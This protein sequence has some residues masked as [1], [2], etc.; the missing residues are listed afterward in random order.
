MKKK[1]PSKVLSLLFAFLSISAL[2]AQISQPGTPPSFSNDQLKSSVPVEKMPKVEVEKL[3]MEDRVMDTIKDIPWRFGENIDV[4]INPQNAGRWDYLNNGDKIW[5]VDVYSENAFTINLIFDRYL[6]PPGAELYVYNQDRSDVIGA[7][8]DYNN[9]DDGYFATTL[10]QG[11]LIT[12]EYY[13]PANASF[14]GELNLETVT[15]AYRDPFEFAKAFGGSGSCN[16]NVACEESIGWEQQIRSAGMLVVGGNGFCSGALINSTESDETPYFLSADHCY[17]NPSTLVVWFNWQSETCDNPPSSPSYNSMSGATLR[18]RNSASDFWLMEFNQPIPDEYEVFYAGWNRTVE[19]TLDETIVGIHH[20]SGDIKKF[21]YAEGGV[22]SSGYGGAP[23]SGSTH[24]RIVWSGGT[25]TEGGSSGSPIFDAQG[26][27]IG[28]LHGGGAACGNTL[29]DWYGRLGVSFT[30]GGSSANSL[31][32]WLDPDDTG[33][34]FIDGYDPL[35]LSIENPEDF[36]ATVVAADS[37]KLHWTANE[38]GNSV[39]IAVNKE[40]VF[41][42]PEGGYAVGEQI[43]NG[44]A[45]LYMGN[46]TVFD[47]T[48]LDF[49]SEYHY[50]IWSFTSKLEYSRGVAASALTP[51][52]SLTDFPFTEGMNGEDIPSCWEQEY[53]SGETPW[54]IG[55]GND[56]GYPYSTHE[57]ESNVFF[58]V[59][60]PGDYGDTTRLMTPAM[61]L[62]AFN[63]AQVSFYYANPS[64][65]SRQDIMNIYYK[66]EP[67][68]PWNLLAVYDTDQFS[69]INAVI[70][71]PET[72]SSTYIAFEGIG[73]GGRGI[74]IDQIEVSGVMEGEIINPVNLIAEIVDDN[75]V[76]L[77]WE[78]DTLTETSPKSLAGYE[79]FMDDDILYQGDDPEETTYLS[80]ALPVGD[81][82]FYV[83]FSYGDGVSSEKSNTVN[84]EILETG[85]EYTLTLTHSGEGSTTPAPGEYLYK[86]DAQ[87][88][89]EAVPGEFHYFKEWN[90][91]DTPLEG[92]NPVVILMESDTQVEAIFNL[93]TYDLVLNAEPE[94]AAAIMEG[95]GEYE[96]GQTAEVEMETAVGYVFLHWMDGD[97]IHST[98][99]GFQMEMTEN[100]QLTAVFEYREHNLELDAQPAEAGSVEGAGTFG[101]NSPV[102]IS[103]TPNPGWIFQNWTQTVDEVETE[104]STDLSFEIVLDQDVSLTANYEPFTPSL[105]VNLE[106]NGT[107][108]PG[109]G[110]HVYSFG[111]EI[112]LNATP[113]DEW[114]FVNWQINDTEYETREVTFTIEENVV[115]TATF[116]PTVS[117]NQLSAE[118]GVRV[119]PIPAQNTLSV[120]FAEEGNWNVSIVNITGHEVHVFEKEV[121]PGKTEILD[122]SHLNDGIY[123][124]R[125]QHGDQ[126]Y[127]TRFIKK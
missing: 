95:E 113:D 14:E 32:S 7:F 102:N 62:A 10:V 23:G 82:D 56:D 38:A 20:P 25:T 101:V 22:Q 16:L 94:E 70:T 51:C 12:I 31:Q 104:V 74:S 116:E 52:N 91:N 76:L 9:Q 8:T 97:Q 69:W 29:P 53:V 57:G 121:S 6:L 86:A 21:S 42:K 73:N 126:I 43:E 99:S 77:N 61:N 2:Q 79:I 117:I 83:R 72:S 19:N 4:N 75:Q 78:M 122:I 96:H 49:N 33:V 39:M 93:N 5:R 58:R 89:I 13:Q 115:A 81:Y 125:S 88:S 107:T 54:K 66:N 37:I 80:D 64:Q 98:R 120:V 112:T 90:V 18:A 15:H 48:G 24:W 123:F 41:G 127:H 114:R 60:G 65:S 17:S 40:N 26:R 28:Q 34:M 3:I 27:I 103:T 106:G 71:I 44:G 67:T 47:H 108:D 84:A 35:G 59:E 124:I 55:V 109:E 111:E 68:E 92:V 45:I 46:D 85:S 50:R 36:T 119:F 100:K 105:M 118:N 63:T 87:V 30:G 11:D 1:L 110:E